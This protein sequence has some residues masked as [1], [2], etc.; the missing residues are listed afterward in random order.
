MIVVDKSQN[1]KYNEKH[2]VDRGAIDKSTRGRRRPMKPGKGDIAEGQTGYGAFSGM[3]RNTLQTPAT[4]V[5]E[6][7]LM[8]TLL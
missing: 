8:T 7:L 1:I 3:E 2:K 6:E 4:I 5:A